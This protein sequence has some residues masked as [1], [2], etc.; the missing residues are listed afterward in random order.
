MSAQLSHQLVYVSAA[1]AP[2]ASVELAALLMKARTNNKRLGVSGILVQHEGSFLQV[3]EGAATVVKPL[4]ARIARDERHHRVV[5]LAQNDVDRVSFGDWSMGFMED[6]R[7]VRDLPGF[8]D[9]FHR[10]F[11]RARLAE[12]S[13]YARTL[14]EAFAAGRFRQYIKA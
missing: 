7:A 14:I 13:G 2:M 10:G 4:F 12:A 9:F 1:K 6:A 8:N 3:L 5:V 11:E